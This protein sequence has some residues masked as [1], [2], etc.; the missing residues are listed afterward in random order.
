MKNATIT[1]SLTTLNTWIQ[2]GEIQS[3]ITTWLN[4]QMAPVANNVEFAYIINDTVHNVTLSATDD[5]N[6][7]HF[8]ALETTEADL[9]SKMEAH[10]NNMV[11]T[12]SS[13]NFLVSLFLVSFVLNIAED[14]GHTLSNTISA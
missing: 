4:E 8:T 6:V 3:L 12:D 11:A 10:Y 13:E 2:T 1:S 5:S 14:M 9:V 7:R